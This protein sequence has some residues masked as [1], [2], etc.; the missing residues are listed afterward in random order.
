MLLY[1]SP[2]NGSGMAHVYVKEQQG[3]TVMIY[4]NLKAIDNAFC[5][6]GTHSQSLLEIN[7]SMQLLYSA[8]LT[9]VA[10]EWQVIRQIMIICNT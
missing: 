8:I 10:S 1:E 3:F 9:A 5:R 4:P 2:S 7:Q 6:G